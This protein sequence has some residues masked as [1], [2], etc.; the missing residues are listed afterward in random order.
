MMESNYT[1][2][3]SGPSLFIWD[4]H[5]C[6]TASDNNYNIGFNRFLLPLIEC[7]TSSPIPLSVHIKAAEPDIAYCRIGGLWTSREAHRKPLKKTDK[8][9][10]RAALDEYKSTKVRG[11]CQLGLTCSINWQL[12]N[13]ARNYDTA[14][15]ISTRL[16][17]IFFKCYFLDYF[18]EFRVRCT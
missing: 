1:N 3:S 15:L 12:R 18:L 8:D 14:I 17:N 4:C 16:K 2:S 6:L 11:W 5:S 10:N 7:S 13:R 9:T